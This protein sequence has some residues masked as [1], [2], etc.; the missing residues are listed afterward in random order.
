MQKFVQSKSN[1]RPGSPHNGQQPVNA[2]RQ[3]QAA[4]LKVSMKAGIARPPTAQGILAR[5]EGGAQHQSA[6]LQQH[7]QRRLSDEGRKGDLYDTDHGSSLDTTNDRSVFQVE[8]TQQIDQQQVQPVH[9]HAEDGDEEEASQ[10]DGD[11]EESQ[12]EFDENIINLLA[13]N[14]LADASYEQRMQ[15][16]H[17]HP[18]LFRQ[19]DGDS[20]PPTTDGNPTEWGEQ[21]EQHVEDLGSPSPSPQ[22][23]HQQNPRVSTHYTQPLRQMHASN[24]QQANSAMRQNPTLWQQSAQLRGQQRADGTVHTRGQ[25]GQQ[26]NAGQLPSSQ[27][28]TYSQANGQQQGLVAP[29]APQARSVPVSQGGHGRMPQQAPRLPAEQRRTQNPA[30]RVTEPAVPANHASATRA[31]IVPIVKQHLE[32]ALAEESPVEEPPVPPEG[33]YD[34]EVLFDMDYN[35]LRDESFD[36]SPR[37]NEPLLPE[38]VREK[39]LED[40]LKY[41]REHLDPT[42]QSQFFSALPTNEWED[43]GDWFLDQFSAIIKHTREARQKK[44][45][46]AQGFEKE[47]EERHT[48]VAKKQRLVEGAM[49][50]MKTQGEGLV[51][52]SPRASKSP[53]PKRA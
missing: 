34:A 27:P 36:K 35:E 29:P 33:D 17:G 5:G 44:R 8:N 24:V 40:R 20:Y 6:T 26:H 3:A 4:N 16:V 53:R 2:Q 11:D 21:Q 22:R 45:K 23:L 19:I 48:H 50:K 49:A 30:L 37:G 18:H 46:K 31:K 52:K 13:E 25:L 9:A 14:D 15:F 38:D 28:P 1:G 41:S 42:A 43:A 32:P 39:S 7:P 10:E 47:I 51:P 12:F